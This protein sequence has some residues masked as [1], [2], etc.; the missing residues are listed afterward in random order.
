MPIAKSLPY[1]S[2][3]NTVAN[4]LREAIVSSELKPGERLIELQLASHFRIGQPTIR[5]ALRE[6]EYQGLVR[7]I[8]NRGTYVIELNAHDLKKIHEVRIAL[9]PIAFELAAKKVT[10]EALEEL[11]EIVDSMAESARKVDCVGFHSQDVEFH[12]RVWGL[13]GNEYIEMALERFV[14]ALFAFVLSKQGRAE[15]LES[16]DQHRKNLAALKSRNPETARRVYL[17]TT[18]GFWQKHYPIELCSD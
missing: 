6:L 14:F 11:G 16:V 3:P 10:P 8:P 13:S 7:R 5:E 9:E 15:F 1:Q 2:R 18:Q 4:A 12:R 17:E